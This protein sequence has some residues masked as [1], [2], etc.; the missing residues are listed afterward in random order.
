MV[1]K[2]IF[3][4]DGL[5]VA[6]G[7]KAKGW[8][9]YYW[10]DVTGFCRKFLKEHEELI[11]VKYFTARVKGDRK[12]WENQDIF[13][14]AN[15]NVKNNKFI[16][17]EG[18]H[19]DEYV[20]CFQCAHSWKQYAEKQTD[21]KI[22][23]EMMKD[24]KEGNCDVS[25]LISGDTDL[26]PVA[27][28]VKAIR[29]NQHMR[30]FFPPER[31]SSD[32]RKDFGVLYLADYEPRFKKNRM[33]EIV[34]EIGTNEIFPIPASWRLDYSTK[35]KSHIKRQSHVLIREKILKDIQP[36][37]KKI[38]KE[39]KVFLTVSKYDYRFSNETAVKITFHPDRVA[40]NKKGRPYLIFNIGS[41]SK[42]ISVTKMIGSSF[43]IQSDDSLH[44]SAL[45]THI[46]EFAKECINYYFNGQKAK[47][48]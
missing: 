33:P 16:L 46:E 21:V 7:L 47:S 39:K 41:H 14:R 44:D 34:P 37:N 29:P 15:E 28:Y 23:L 35:S 27:K 10:L 20:H 9:K 11:A 40:K 17:I 8:K 38:N 26:I 24:A 32:F 30:I 19:R 1:K 25:I 2:V 36:I 3:Y 12:A 22:A 18:Y 4:V 6:N 5:N 13:L 43:E 31:H 48:N 45:T 42:T